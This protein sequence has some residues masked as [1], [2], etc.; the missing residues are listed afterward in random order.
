MPIIATSA[1]VSEADQAVIRA[2][3]FDDFLPKPITWPRLL[4]LL[5]RYL[6]L[7]WVYAP[8][9]EEAE[10]SEAA[11]AVVPPLEELAALYELARLGDVLAAQARA[12][13][14]EQRDPRW[15]PFAQRVAQLA[16]QFE[17]QK[18]LALLARYLPPDPHV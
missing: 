4:A 8:D 12:I 18:L 1:S 17:A 7:E 6:Q 2:A 10:A 15:R 11:E 5:G 3:G 13:Q 16:G 9:W 14:L